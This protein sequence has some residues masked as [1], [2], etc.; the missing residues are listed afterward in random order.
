VTSEEHYHEA[1][2]LSQAKENPFGGQ[3]HPGSD[4]LAAA[5]VHATLAV[6][7]KLGDIAEGLKMLTE[8]QHERGR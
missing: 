4:A 3:D 8:V 1:E 6:A 7:G 2:R 5:Q